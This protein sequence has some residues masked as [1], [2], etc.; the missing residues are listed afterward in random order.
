VIGVL[1]LAAALLTLLLWGLWG[2]A[3]KYASTGITWYQLYFYSNL[4]I[5]AVML[6]MLLVF[7]DALAVPGEKAGYALAAGFLGTLGYIFLVLAIQ[8]GKV[9]VVVPMTSVYPAVTVLL[10]LVLLGEELSL[11]QALGVA[12][13][14]VAVVLLSA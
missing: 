8:S 1:W 14:L 7:R 6:A 4:V 2:V 13:A 3:L 11:R 5:L 10:S 9:S 12:A